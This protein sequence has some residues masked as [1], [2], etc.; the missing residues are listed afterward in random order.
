[1]TRHGGCSAEVVCITV[2]PGNR[3][4][5]GSSAIHIATRLLLPTLRFEALRVRNPAT[6]TTSL[7]RVRPP[8]RFPMPTIALSYWMPD[9]KIG[10]LLAHPIMLH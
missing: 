7:A 4:L 9:P 8:E 5:R 1:M 2:F 6:L 10:H 3:L